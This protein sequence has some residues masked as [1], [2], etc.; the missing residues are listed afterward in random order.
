MT[1]KLITITITYV[2]ALGSSSRSILELRCTEA[3]LGHDLIG[4]SNVFHNLV[5]ATLITVNHTTDSHLMS[6]VPGCRH[7]HYTAASGLQLYM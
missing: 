3:K 4:F 1:N 5:M 2:S 6:T 7:A